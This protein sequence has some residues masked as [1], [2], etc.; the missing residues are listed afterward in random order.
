MSLYGFLSIFNKFELK[1]FISIISLKK[2]VWFL[3][4]N[5]LTS[6]I[7]KFNGIAFNEIAFNEI[8]FNEIAFNKIAFNEIAFNG[9]AFI[10]LLFDRHTHI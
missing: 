1:F 6:P 7:Y 8:A 2:Y 3:M 4:F 10:K 5:S 9:I